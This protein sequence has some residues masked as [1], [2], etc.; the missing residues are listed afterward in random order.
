MD[1]KYHQYVSQ[2]I[3]RYPGLIHTARELMTL[4]TTNPN[5]THISA[6]IGTSGYTPLSF[7]SKIPKQIEH[8]LLDMLQSCKHW[9]YVSDWC[10]TYDY[11]I[12]G[13]ERLQIH[14][15]RTQKNIYHYKI[16]PTFMKYMTQHE[17]LFQSP[18]QTYNIKLDGCV[19]TDLDKVTNLQEYKQ[20]QICREKHFIIRSTNLPD[21]SWRYSIR[22]IWQGTSIMEVEKKMITCCPRYEFVLNVMNLPNQPIFTESQVLILFTSLLLKLRDLYVYPPV[23]L[24]PRI[25]DLTTRQIFQ[26]NVVPRQ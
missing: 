24:K 11:I 12:S 13:T 19:R 22:C 23:L 17:N 18:L 7:T 10:L 16:Q 2:L 14:Y 20:L 4:Y 6:T 15:R 26:E 9:E 3:I 25:P 8:G 5:T 1:K 21:I